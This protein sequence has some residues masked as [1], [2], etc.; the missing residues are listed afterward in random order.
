MQGGRE[1]RSGYDTRL[2]EKPR[3]F[4]GQET[5]FAEFRFRLHSY[6]DVVDEKVTEEVEAAEQHTGPIALPTEEATA[7]RGRALYALF[8]A[9]VWRRAQGVAGRGKAQMDSKS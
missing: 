8:G 2:F 3:P 6:L 1:G 9:A 5:D 7:R 4:S